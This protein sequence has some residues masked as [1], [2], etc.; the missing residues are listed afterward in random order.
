MDC[1]SWSN[2]GSDYNNAHGFGKIE[3]KAFC[4]D[5]TALYLIESVKERNL[6][7]NTA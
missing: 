6:E 5:I 3:R 1:V 4:L 7:V 2:T